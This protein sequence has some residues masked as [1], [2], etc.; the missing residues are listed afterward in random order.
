MPSRLSIEETVLVGNFRASG[1]Q[2]AALASL[3][4]VLGLPE[5]A[6]SLIT[7]CYAAFDRE[8]ASQNSVKT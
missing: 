2:L 6:E 3:A 8:V 4:A 5:E 7:L 1:V